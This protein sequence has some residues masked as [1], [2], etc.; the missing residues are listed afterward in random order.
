LGF[1]QSRLSPGGAEGLADL[2]A[3]MAAE[4]THDHKVAGLEDGGPA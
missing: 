1:V 4:I 3:A 2:I